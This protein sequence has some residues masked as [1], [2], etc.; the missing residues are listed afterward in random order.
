MASIGFL[1]IWRNP[2]MYPY[3]FLL[4]IQQLLSEHHIPP[5]GVKVVTDGH[6]DGTSRVLAEVE[7]NH[8]N[9]FIISESWFSGWKVSANDRPVELLSVSNLL[10]V[11][12]S[13]GQHRVEFRYQPTS[14]TVGALISGLTLA[15]TILA[16]IREGAKIYLNAQ[17][18][19][20][21]I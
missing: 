11:Q 1:Q 21:E 10:A 9:V 8:E 14:F 3:A 5:A 16:F 19:G 4:P 18:N 15:F 13:P 12:L 7:V 17:N 20:K 6:R 2:E